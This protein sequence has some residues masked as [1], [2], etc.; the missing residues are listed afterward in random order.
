MLTAVYL[1]FI[2]ERL[3]QMLSCRLFDAWF[4]HG[5]SFFILAQALVHNYASSKNVFTHCTIRRKV[6]RQSVLSDIAS[7]QFAKA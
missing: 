1:P 3:F 6:A 2:G 5:Y 4:V 7:N